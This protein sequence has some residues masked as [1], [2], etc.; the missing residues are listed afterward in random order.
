MSNAYTHL[1]PAI[2]RDELIEQHRP[3]VKTL[4]I[5]VLK[6]LPRHIDLDELI[7][8]GNLGLV[9]AAE[10]YDPR[11]ST[12]FKTFAYYRIKGATY[13]A[14]RSMGP[15]SRG[16]YARTQLS[17]RAN[18]VMQTIADD[19]HAGSPRGETAFDEI[20][21]A[22]AAIDVLLPVFLLS[23]DSEELPELVDDNPDALTEVERDELID[24][25]RAIAAE[26]AAD[27]REIIECIYFKNQTISQVAISLGI[28]KS[29]ASRLHAKAI[30]QMRE[31]AQRR[32]LIST[33]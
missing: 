20:T 11:H 18:D 8:C 31:L 5:S 32:G 2:T 28:S 29:W 16:D 30:K 19:H 33:D 14:L 23:L 6:K 9:E 26:L 21:A 4:A 15:L 27:D 12:S 10:R 24:L 7:A 17:A 1:S 22:Q 3:F 13:D 25:V